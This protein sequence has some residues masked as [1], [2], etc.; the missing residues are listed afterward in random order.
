MHTALSCFMRA[1]KNH[2]IDSNGK[3]LASL[4]LFLKYPVVK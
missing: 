1:D 3:V 2:Y 4:G